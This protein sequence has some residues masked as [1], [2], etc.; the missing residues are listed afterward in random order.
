MNRGYFTYGM[1]IVNSKLLAVNLCKAYKSL[2]CAL[3][4]T[5]AMPA[6]A[7]NESDIVARYTDSLHVAATRTAESTD[8]I[9][10]YYYQLFL[11]TTYYSSAAKTVLTL[12]SAENA[13]G[14]ASARRKLIELYLKNPSV[15]SHYDNQYASEDL[16]DTSAPSEGGK[17]A[18]D[19]KN[20]ISQLASDKTTTTVNTNPV[21]MDDIQ[22]EVK[23]PNFWKVTG[24]FSMQFQQNY[25][26]ENWYRGGDNNNTMLTSLALTAT[27]NDTKRITWE[28]KLDMRL[29][30]VTTK[31]DTCHSFLTNNDRIQLN[32]K[33]NIR[34]V[35]AWKYTISGEAKT[36]FLP[37]YRANNRRTFSKFMSPI[38]A[39]VSIGMDFNPSLKN[40][41]SLSIA[42]LPLSYKLR[43]IGSDDENI[44]K[45]YNFVN[46]T[47]QQDYGSRIELNC[48][49][50]IVKNL[51]WKC[52]SYYFT[53]YEYAEA[54]LENVFS[55]A[56]SKYI[57]SEVYTLW[58]FDDNRGR[59]FYDDN[60][61]YF[62]F[63]E[64][65]TLGLRYNF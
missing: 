52:R 20:A 40:G 11:P 16:L 25:F 13:D 57:S 12:D 10:P 60:L 45:V 29:G 49:L 61:G 54:E 43:Y 48:K 33:L 59:K 4:A 55:F 14:I 51:T 50:N 63:K 19:I 53:S 46:R 24:S 39:Y 38:D 56:F 9:N 21:T 44:H 30:F 22:L 58:R 62:Q 64:Y 28:N 37:G 26:S 31:S 1:V 3:L 35:K 8:E 27:Y 65:F 18:S 17:P 2:V 5:A 7:Q 6:I 41:N 42:L 34:A 23:R 15:A 36:Q 32:T 47:T